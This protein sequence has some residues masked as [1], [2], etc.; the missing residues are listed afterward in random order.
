M[1]SELT[2]TAP[3][4]WLTGTVDAE[5]VDLSVTLSEDLPC[6]W[7]GHV[8]FARRIWS[9]FERRD[10]PIPQSCSSLGPYQTSFLLLDEHCGTHVDGPTHFIP[11]EESGLPWSGPLGSVSCDRLDL[12]RLVGPAAV[13]DL[14]SLLEEDSRGRSPAITKFHL[15]AFEAAHGALRPGEVVLLFTG[16]SSYYVNAPDGHR[17]VHEPVVTRTGAGWP[18]LD[19]EGAIL[20]AER[21]VRLVGIDAPSIGSVQNGAEVHREGLSR[22]LLF[23]E[24]LTGLAALPV[25]G[26]FFMFLPLKIAGSGGCPGRAIALLPRRS[27]NDGNGV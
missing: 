20:L 18:A 23:V 12:A 24:M 15:R 22:G 26:A 14:R 10:L 5:I 6:T 3:E 19:A 2:L 4:G 21:G 9:W 17:F 27:D 8:P 25:R 16:W 7:P 1:P 13:L 11:P